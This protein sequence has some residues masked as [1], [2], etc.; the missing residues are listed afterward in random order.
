M[1]HVCAPHT[2][3]RRRNAQNIEAS[4]TCT[5]MRPE[6]PACTGECCPVHGR[7]ERDRLKASGLYSHASC[8]LG[9]VSAFHVISCSEDQMSEQLPGHEP[10]LRSVPC[11]HNLTHAHA[12]RGERGRLKASGLCSHAREKA[13]RDARDAQ[14][15]AVPH[16]RV[17][18]APVRSG[19]KQHMHMI[20]K[21]VRSR[22]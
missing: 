5:H 15:A 22:R 17:R 20:K 8:M 4:F 11:T 21:R 16:D 10:I 14:S 9:S 12:C 2:R 18:S 19:Q 1:H 6:E 3:E 13:A 7:R